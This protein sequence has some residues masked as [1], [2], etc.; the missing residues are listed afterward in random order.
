M[1]TISFAEIN[2]QTAVFHAV[3]NTPAAVAVR[4]IETLFSALAECEPVERAEILC[5]LG[6]QLRPAA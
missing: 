1:K 3:H 6:E 4:A 5:L 2:A